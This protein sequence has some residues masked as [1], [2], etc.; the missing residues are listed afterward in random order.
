MKQITLG[1]MV[2]VVGRRCY[3][4]PIATGNSG[5]AQGIFENM[6]T[7]PNNIVKKKTSCVGVGV[8]CR[9]Q[10]RR[11]FVLCYIGDSCYRRHK[12]LKTHENE[13]ICYGWWSEN[14]KPTCE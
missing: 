7:H 1:G 3:T 14:A 4:W 5:Q 10:L 9:M 2:L 11:R 12:A 6:L 8:R 13:Q